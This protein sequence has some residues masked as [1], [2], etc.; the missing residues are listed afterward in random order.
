MIL[1][2]I[3]LEEDTDY[4]TFGILKINKVVFCV[5]LEPHDEGNA[6][7]VSSIPAQQYLCKR[8][9]SPKF[10]ETFEVTNVPNRSSILFHAGNAKGDTTGCVLLGEHFGKL[11]AYTETRGILNSGKTMQ[12]FLYMT[13]GR[14]V[15]HL[16]IREVY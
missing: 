7:F 15:L 11:R 10:G 16:T 13:R 8:V 3:R 4:G 14:N 6:P 9:V 12:G 1:E 2:L 5:T